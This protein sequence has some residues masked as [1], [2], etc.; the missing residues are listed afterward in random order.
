MGYVYFTEEQ[1]ERANTVDLKDFLERQ[2]ERLLR[3]G[4]EWRMSSDH[5]I[6]IRGNRWYDHG[7]GGKGGAAIDFVIYYYGK[8]FPDAVSMLLGGEQGE[9]YRQSKKQEEIPRG[10][11]TLPAANENMIRVFAYLLKS[12]MLDYGVVCA[13][14]EKKLIYESLE[15]SRDGSRQY[16]NAIFVGYD[17]EGKARHAHKKGIYT[18]GKSYRGNLESSDP[19]YSFHWNGK[20]SEIY[21]FEAPIDMLSYISLNKADWKNHSYISLCGVGSQALFQ[22]LKDHPALTK[23]YLCLDHDEA[24]MEAAARIQEKLTEAG[25]PD[26]EL[27]LSHWKDWNEDLKA[28]HGMEAVPAEEKP[29]PELVE[30]KMLQMA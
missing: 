21:V 2:G 15:P 20:S 7:S 9:I 30:E 23:I 13:F 14:A 18:V 24:G 29:P 26:T 3:S 12:R 4:P 11:F 16:H 17:P 19:R 27:Y 6:T 8:S 10:P 28:A 22:T 5:S 1:K 25:Y